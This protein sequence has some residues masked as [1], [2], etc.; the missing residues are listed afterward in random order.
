[1]E[2]MDQKDLKETWDIK[3][4]MEQ[5]D[6]VDKKV[7]FSMQIRPTFHGL[8]SHNSVIAQ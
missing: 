7:V 1:M 2:I 5:M 8:K 6:R 4:S 3:D